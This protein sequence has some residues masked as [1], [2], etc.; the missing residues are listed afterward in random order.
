MREETKAPRPRRRKG[1]GLDENKR[2]GRL[3][4]N[5]RMEGGRSA[6]DLSSETD[7]LWVGFVRFVVNGDR[8]H[9]N[10]SILTTVQSEMLNC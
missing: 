4:K 7:L 6:G 9:V 1:R 5:R 10:Y 8:S 3:R 2:R